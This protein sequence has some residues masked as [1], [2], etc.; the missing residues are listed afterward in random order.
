[1]EITA[2][3]ST[4]SP[5]VESTLKTRRIDTLLSKPLMQEGLTHLKSPSVPES[6]LP[7]QEPADV[8]PSSTTF[9]TTVRDFVACLWPHAKASAQQLGIDPGLLLAQAALETGWGEKQVA[10]SKNYFNIKARPGE[11]GIQ[12]TTTEYVD[13]KPVSLKALFRQYQNAGESFFAL[14][15]L[16]K[17]ADRYH[18]LASLTNDPQAWL[19]ALQSAGFA[20]DPHYAEKVMAIYQSKTLRAAIKSL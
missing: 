20:T 4:P 8:N 5:W 3:T 6:P 16:L 9:N 11:P 14:T 18:A 15:N 17:H 7:L 2:I 13:A 1:M 10:G 19:S 12:S